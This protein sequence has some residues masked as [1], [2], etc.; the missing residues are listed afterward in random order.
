MSS[1]TLSAL[2]GSRPSASLTVLMDDSV[3]VSLIESSAVFTLSI[4]EILNLKKLYIYLF[5]LKIC[6]KNLKIIN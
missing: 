3:S 4:R 5:R 6:F 1:E 2:D